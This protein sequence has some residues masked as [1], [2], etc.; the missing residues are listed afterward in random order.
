MGITVKQFEKIISTPH[1]KPA[2]Y[3]AGDCLYFRVGKA[4]L[5]ERGN[6]RVAVSF[7]MRYETDGKE[8]W[9]G[10]GPLSVYGLSEARELVRKKR[11]MLREGNDPIKQTAATRRTRATSGDGLTF[12]EAA[13]TRLGLIES[14]FTNPR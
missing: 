3:P 7:L 14:K 11:Q 1:D 9:H 13:E 2:R 6:K 5:D 12:K 4:R 10:I 8:H